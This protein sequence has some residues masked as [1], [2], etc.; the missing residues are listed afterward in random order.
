MNSAQRHFMVLKGIGQPE[1]HL[2]PSD[3]DRVISSGREKVKDQDLLMLADYPSTKAP[4]D[5]EEIGLA[6]EAR[7]AAKLI[8]RFRPVVQSESSGCEVY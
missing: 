4:K 3:K 5:K 8:N 1:N 6:P 2:L 7:Q